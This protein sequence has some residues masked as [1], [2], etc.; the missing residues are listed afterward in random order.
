MNRKN[1][2]RAIG[3]TPLMALIAKAKTPAK[4]PIKQY[5]K[6]KLPEK[7]GIDGTQTWVTGS[8]MSGCYMGDIN[9]FK[10]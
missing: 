6:Y 7:K 4:D 9:S 2:L 3:V 5:E 8:C 1:F 10:F